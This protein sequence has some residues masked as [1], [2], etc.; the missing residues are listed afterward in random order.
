MNTN[1]VTQSVWNPDFVTD[2][3]QFLHLS[4]VQKD[5]ESVLEFIKDKS[6]TTYEK[7]Q[8]LIDRIEFIG[9]LNLAKDEACRQEYLFGKR[10][11]RGIDWDISALRI[12]LAL[13]CVDILSTNF[14]PFDAWIVKNCSDFQSGKDIHK[15]L[16]QKSAEYRDLFQLSSNFVKAFTLASGGLQA[17]ISKNLL[18]RSGENKF[19]EIKRIATY[20]YRVRNKYT[21]EGRRFFAGPILSDRRQAIG[22]RDEDYLQ[23]NNGFDLVDVVLK[24]AKEQATRTLEKYGRE[25]KGCG[26]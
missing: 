20:L 2:L 16:K 15:Y 11:V 10:E 18:V 17:E 9:H 1:Y 7:L 21:H 4:M 22:P 26:K 24:V 13:S 23:I 25:Q 5:L 8:T 14:E 12:Y 6:P 19:S 3:M